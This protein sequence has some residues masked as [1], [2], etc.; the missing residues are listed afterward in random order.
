MEA[1]ATNQTYENW[2]EPSTPKL[3]VYGIF[4]DESNRNHYGMSN[5][6]YD[7]VKGYITVGDRIVQA[8][9]IGGV[10]NVALTGLTVDMNP[11]YWEM[12][13]LLESGYERIQVITTGGEE[14]YMYAGF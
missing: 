12:L 5:P 9:R 1:G 7:T 13:D 2:E 6:H 14:A 8:V 11:E 4:L 3:F 10:D